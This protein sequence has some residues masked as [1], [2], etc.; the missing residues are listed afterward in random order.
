MEDGAIKLGHCFSEYAE[1][2]AGVSW[3]ELVEKLNC[4]GWIPERKFKL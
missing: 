4:A 1:I 2:T 3:G